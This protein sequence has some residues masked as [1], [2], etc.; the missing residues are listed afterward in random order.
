MDSLIIC[1]LEGGEVLWTLGQ[2]PIFLS[3][4]ELVSGIIYYIPQL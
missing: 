2:N 1:K 4:L 3:L